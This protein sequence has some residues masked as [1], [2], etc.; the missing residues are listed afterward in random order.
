MV[1]DFPNLKV[2]GLLPNPP[3]P[4]GIPQRITVREWDVIVAPREIELKRARESAAASL[5]EGPDEGGWIRHRCCGTICAVK[6]LPNPWMAP[7]E[8]R[9]GPHH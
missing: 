6:S 4:K 7:K 8:P 2:G 3:D 5:P 9:G 1:R